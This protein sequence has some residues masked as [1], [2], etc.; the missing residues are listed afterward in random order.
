M[1]TGSELL[2]GY[3][4]EICG[5]VIERV[6]RKVERVNYDEWGSTSANNTTWRH[7]A[8]SFQATL[9]QPYTKT[10]IKQLI[11]SNLVRVLLNYAYCAC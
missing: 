4:R 7:S 1:S 11:V 2:I 8:A 10:N 5:S 9:F 6:L 3:C